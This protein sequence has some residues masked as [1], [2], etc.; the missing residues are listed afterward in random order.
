MGTIQGIYEVGIG[1]LDLLAQVQYW[2]Q[3]GYRIGEIGRLSPEGAE[4]LY[5][6]RSGLQSVRLLHQNAD[7]GLLRLM[8]WES[9]T[10]PGLGLASMKVIGN[11]WGTTLTN[12]LL[13]L[14]NHFELLA[15]RSP[16]TYR[17][18]EPLWSQIYASATPARAWVDPLL[19]V[20]ESLWLTPLTRH[21]FFQRFNYQ[22]P[23]YG[24][25]NPHS[26]F[27]TSQITH[28]GLVIQDDSSEVLDFY[29][30]VLGLLR[31][32]DG[33]VD[34]YEDN[35]AARPILD[36]GP[37]DYYYTT[38]FDDPRSSVTDISQVRS[39]RL[40]VIRFPQ[41]MALENKLL[42]SRPGQ[43][44]ISLYTYRV[45]P[46]SEFWERVKA[47]AATQVT[48]IIQNEFQEPSFSFMAPDG[49]FWTLVG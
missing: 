45:Q 23:H 19:G 22:L 25:V 33:L 11:R 36:L 15:Q 18:T 21:V 43:L 9:P 13:N 20:R 24:S 12:D 2:Q 40:K 17:Y 42:E 34:R 37:G 39:G 32:R 38:D 41:A 29:D 47:S 4:R 44:G 6:V 7:H 10:G 31:A 8:A 46:I 27:Q 49:Y 1:T 48:E 28:V 14:L 26:F 30:Q 35:P 3:F 5:G 16:D